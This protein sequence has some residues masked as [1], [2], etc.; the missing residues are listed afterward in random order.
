MINDEANA[1]VIS[2]SGIGMILWTNAALLLFIVLY[3]IAYGACTR[4]FS[5]LV[6]ETRDAHQRFTAIAG[7]APLFAPAAIVES[8]VRGLSVE[9]SYNPHP[10][11]DGEEYDSWF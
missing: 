2:S 8:L 11:Q 4:R 3:V 5:Y 6:T 10:E 7:L 1:R 9:V